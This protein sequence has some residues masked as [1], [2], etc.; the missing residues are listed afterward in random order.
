MADLPEEKKRKVKSSNS[1]KKSGS[2]LRDR[3][4]PSSGFFGRL[5][6]KLSKKLAK[7]ADEFS[8]EQ[9]P[10]PDTDTEKDSLVFDIPESED[11]KSFQVIQGGKKPRNRQREAIAICSVIAAILVVFAIINLLSPA[12]IVEGTKVFFAGFGHSGKFPA[13]VSN[14]PLSMIE[15]CGSDI[16]ML[17]DTSVYCYKSN[18]RQVYTIQHAYQDPAMAVSESRTIVFD[19]ES[20][21]YMVLNRTGVLYEDK[22]DG[23]IITAG[24]G[25]DGSYAIS[26]YSASYVSSVKVYK[27]DFKERF[28]W[29]S[30]DSYVI[31][32]DISPNGKRLAVGCIKAVDGEFHSSVKL[33]NVKKTDTLAS[34]QYGDALLLSVSFTSKG[35]VGAVLSDRYV[36]MD[37]ESKVTAFSYGGAELASFDNTSSSHTAILLTKYNDASNNS[38]VLIDG[39]GEVLFDTGFENEA[40]SV[41]ASDRYVFVLG[42]G[43]VTRFPKSG[44]NPKTAKSNLDCT[45]IAA[46][47]SRAV[48]LGSSVIDKVSF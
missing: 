3:T 35:N 13:E 16:M 21:R 41:A 42:K 31:S 15:R 23:K 6:S 1:S 11:K 45:D 40:V 44:E 19:R 12:G 7:N 39:E 32:T 29:N 48:V 47:G 4:G 24:V 2:V 36:V 37:E 18:G 17:T 20:E 43:S 38:V 33:F 28:V 14:T 30:S 5:G 9:D 25:D 22:A 27:S 46:T 10:A 34:V 26:T 8:R